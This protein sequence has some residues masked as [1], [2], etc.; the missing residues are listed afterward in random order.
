[1]I[2]GPAFYKLLGIAESV[3]EPT[4]YHL[5]Q[6]HP[7]AVTPA[8]VDGALKEAKAR[9]RQNIPGPR[10]IPIVS[11]IEDELDRAAAILRDP[12]KRAEYNRRLAR[13]PRT[14]GKQRSARERARL[15]GACRKAVRAMVDADGC[16]HD[17]KR[18][19]LA[20]R[21]AEL[22]LPADQVQYVLDNIPRPVGSEAAGS[23]EQRQRDLDEA[24]DF[25]EKAIDLEI[26]GGMLPPAAERKL[27]TMADRFGIAEDV[28]AERIDRRLA[29]IGARRGQPMTSL[30]GQFKLH[31]LAMF[32]TGDATETDRQ[33]LLTLGVAEGLSARDA[34]TILAEYLPSPEAAAASEL[35]YALHDRPLSEWAALAEGESLP[36]RRGPRKS[37]KA[38]RYIVDVAV[39][40]VA[41]LAAIGV[42]RL[43]AGRFA[44]PPASPF[45]QRPAGEPDE[46]A[47]RPASA[48]ATPDWQVLLTNAF[49][50]PRS[51]DEARRLFNEAGADVRDRALRYVA[52]LLAA[53]CS[54]REQAA[55][56]WLVRTLLCC[57]PAGPEAQDAAVRALVYELSASAAAG[58]LAEKKAYRQASLLA[59]LLFLR[60]TPGFAVTDPVKVERFAD[61]CTAAWRESRRASPS[62][63]ANDPDRLARAVT[64]GGSLAIY[65]ARADAERFSAV[66][67]EVAKVA[68]DPGQTG[69]QEASRALLAAAGLTGHPR[70]IRDATRLALC[71]VV[72][73]ASDPFV[74]NRAQATLAS[75]LKLGY[76]DALRSAPL[77]TAAERQSAAAGFRRVIRAGT[78]RPA[79]APAATELASSRPATRPA[80]PGGA[81]ERKLRAAWADGQDTPRLLADLSSGMLACAER[82]ARFAA[83]SDALTR[84]L[85]DVLRED[86]PSLRSAR[87]TRNV[88]LADTREALTHAG[89]A[90]L[91]AAFAAKLRDD[92][93]SSS[94]G[95]RY[96]AIE[97]LRVLGGAAASDVL[98]DKLHEITAASRPDLPTMN[99]L[100][101]ALIDVDDRKLP[102]KLAALISTA[103][104]NYAAHR[105]VMTLLEG[106]GQ[107][108]SVQRARY[109]LPVN[110]NSKE[111]TA[112]A[113]LWKNLAVSSSWGPQRLAGSVAGQVG[114]PPAWQ[115]EAATQKL[116]AV[117]VHYTTAAGKLLRAHRPSE[118]PDEEDRIRLL[119]GG[120]KPGAPVTHVELTAALELLVGQLTRLAREHPNAKAFAVKIDMIVL[121]DKARSLACETPL[122]TAAVRLDT[123]GRLL[124][125]LVLEGDSGEGSQAVVDAARQAR[126][127]AVAGA[128][129]VLVAMRE[130][131]YYNLILLGRLPPKGP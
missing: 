62:D 28:A 112:C 50:S 118:A 6:I 65:A 3:A 106:T 49:R 128:A 32:P 10:F 108:G 12:E 82:I 75:L 22:S 45:V 36:A 38:P 30:A 1:M 89:A 60:P 16:L 97:Q 90:P 79:T 46:Q 58:D 8:L 83:R 51:P 42:Y 92:L 116:L 80:A 125:I 44:G 59:S 11:M 85:L 29:E 15:V 130:H 27:M 95:L 56:E 74:A 70:E 68:A 76:D 91:D 94:T 67:D 84:E 102:G 123:A 120:P 87:L 114:P 86:D 101:R 73:R 25:F 5:L 81:L 21:L 119:P 129:N 115:P 41:A 43:V 13:T 23:P 104:S 19:E 109:Q 31:V 57:P 117:F 111:R 113:G 127:K 24:M 88:V 37:R 17:E 122:Q 107:T 103:R 66:A 48:P 99:R 14:K 131:C 34:E 96:R 7:R 121:H 64:A 61:E 47:A 40:L 55:A 72:E 39:G 52:T 69:S 2:Y 53:D 124:E 9:L 126:G 105:I 110:H 18:D 33:R 20:A 78:T 100:L 26:D 71:H 77:G 54:A 63:P 93:R 4:A 35:D 98:V